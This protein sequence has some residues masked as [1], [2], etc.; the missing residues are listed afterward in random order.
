MKR[1]FS[2]FKSNVVQKLCKSALKKEIYRILLFVLVN[3]ELNSILL[4]HAEKLIYILNWQF[5]TG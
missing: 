3:L 2:G 4:N 5:L 1:R